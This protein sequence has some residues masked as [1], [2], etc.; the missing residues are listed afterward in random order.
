MAVRV[1]LVLVVPAVR[2]RL[3]VVPVARVP[4]AVRA[5]VVP[6]VPVARVPAVPGRAR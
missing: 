4:T 2:V 6:V 3:A 5:P 1:P